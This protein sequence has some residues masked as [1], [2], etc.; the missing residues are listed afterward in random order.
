MM[1][2]TALMLAFALAG[3]TVSAGKD[4]PP[5][6][7]TDPV[8][9]DSTT[10][11]VSIDSAKV[12]VLDLCSTG[13]FVQ[14][15]DS[16]WTCAS[17]SSNDPRVDG[18]TGRVDTL[19]GSSSKQSGEITTLQG[20]VTTLQGDFGTCAL[21]SDLNLYELKTDMSNYA[22]TNDLKAYAKTS[23]LAA[24]AKETE[25]TTLQTTVATLQTAVTSLQTAVTTLQTNVTDLQTQQTAMKS[26]LDALGTA[27]CPSG[28]TNI[29]APNGYVV[30][31]KQEGTSAD[32][33]EIVKV[34]NFWIDR[35]EGSACSGDF[36][37][38]SVTGNSTTI[39]ACSILNKV[40]AATVSWF[41]AAQACANSGKRLCTNLEWQTAA[42]GTPDPGA[43]GGMGA[44]L[45]SCYTATAATGPRNTGQGS[46]CTSRFGAMDMVGNVWEWVADWQQGS[47]PNSNADNGTAASA[48]F[49]D[50]GQYSVAPATHQGTGAA[51][52][53]AMAR[54]GHFGD[55]VM[56]GVFA[57]YLSEAPSASGP[58]VGFRCCMSR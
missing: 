27:N 57:V 2:R 25:V 53:A 11:T 55:G 7:G 47:G 43:A 4:V 8:V 18:L 31:S 35:Y 20:D 10:Q 3:C 42:S 22:T 14:K 26:Q 34:G 24:Y 49:G 23:D 36:T 13:Q 30:C 40:P 1:R 38:D 5:V 58:S 33:D 37:T 41:Q 15:T 51:L 17:G 6:K 52:S 32:Y 12:P 48:V 39:R 16:G 9:V 29:A 50:D 56:A 46:D 44:L 28:Y 19:E 54:G 21:K 45:T